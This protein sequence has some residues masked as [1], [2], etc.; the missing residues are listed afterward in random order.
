ME[1]VEGVLNPVRQPNLCGRLGM[2]SGGDALGMD[3]LTVAWW[4]LDVPGC[5]SR[6]LALPSYGCW[7]LELLNA[8]TQ[9][10]PGCLQE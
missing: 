6:C 9:A 8:N 3:G 2:V 1:A 7:Y 10:A 5:N 4:Y